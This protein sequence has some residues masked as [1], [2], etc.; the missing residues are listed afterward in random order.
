MTRTRGTTTG[1]GG[2]AG[3]PSRRCSA[4][5]PGA[6]RTRPPRSAGSTLSPWRLPVAASP[7]RT[8]STSPPRPNGRPSTSFAAHAPATALAADPPTPDPSGTPLSTRSATPPSAPDARRTQAAARPAV[9]RSGSLWEGRGGLDRDAGR[10]GPPRR[11]AV[12]APGHAQAERVEAGAEVRERGR[13]EGGD[14]VGRGGGHGRGRVRE[15]SRGGVGIT[16]PPRRPAPQTWR[17]P[18]EQRRPGLAV[19]GGGA[20]PS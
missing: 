18:A 6:T 8:A 1:S 12:A 16:T 9:F 19:P 2:G 11:H 3:R 7:S 20:A 17:G 5:S 13:A 14:G 15:G 4:G 10:V